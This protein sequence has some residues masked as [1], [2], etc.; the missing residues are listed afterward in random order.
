[1]STIKSRKN[2]VIDT[3]VSDISFAIL[4]NEWVDIVPIYYEEGHG[5]HPIDD[6]SIEQELLSVSLKIGEKEFNLLPTLDK[7]QQQIF[8]DYI[9]Q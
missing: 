7:E 3:E 8:I 6:S 4:Y 5:I 9:N 1:M 2:K